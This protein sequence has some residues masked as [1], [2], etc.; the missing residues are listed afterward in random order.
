MEIK[1]SGPRGD[2]HLA[3]PAGRPRRIRITHR[4]ASREP[5]R[6]PRE[7]TGR[8]LHR[9]RPHRSHLAITENLNGKVV[10]WMEKVSDEQYRAPPSTTR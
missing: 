9:L 3:F 8:I 1:P 10:D 7:G 4:S 5:A 2:G 6:S